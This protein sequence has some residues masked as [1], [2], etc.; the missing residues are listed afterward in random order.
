MESERNHKVELDSGLDTCAATSS[1]LI[2]TACAPRHR[3]WTADA[4][5]HPD[6]HGLESCVGRVGTVEA[7]AT[8][9]YRVA[10]FD[11]PFHPGRP[12]IQRHERD[13]DAQS[14]NLA[15]G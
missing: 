6:P 13:A 15:A 9:A 5:T 2:T 10:P 11:C 1:E 8:V 4:G 12:Y 7:E 14:P 3:H